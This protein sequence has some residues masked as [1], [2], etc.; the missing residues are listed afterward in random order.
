MTIIRDCEVEALEKRYIIRSLRN[1]V[2]FVL[3]WVALVTWLCGWC[4]S[5]EGVGVVLAW[6]AC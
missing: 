5:A 4:A 1:S 6:G 2:L 3:A